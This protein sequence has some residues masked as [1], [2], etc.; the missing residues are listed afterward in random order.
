[1]I[2]T[3]IDHVVL[4]VRDLQGAVAFYSEVLGCPVERRSEGLGL[5][6][7]RAGASL[8]DLVAA[9]GKLGLAGGV[10]P[11]STGHNMDH[12]CLRIA[13][14][15]TESTSAELVSRGIAVGE[16]GRRYGASGE[17]PS[18]LPRGQRGQRFGTARV[19]LV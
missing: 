7:L 16:E 12:L 3:G 5:V 9:D 19:N 2:V 4:R 15:E 14:L 11:A 17:G 6:Q 8:I 13:S 1:M 18:I 10:A